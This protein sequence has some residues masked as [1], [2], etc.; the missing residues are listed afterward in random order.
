MFVTKDEFLKGISEK[1]R[2]RYEESIAYHTAKSKREGRIIAHAADNLYHVIQANGD[3]TPK[4]IVETYKMLTEHFEVELS[5][6][7]ERY[8]KIAEKSN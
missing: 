1:E 5:I 4:L 3:N 8:E 2:E 6:L 7:K